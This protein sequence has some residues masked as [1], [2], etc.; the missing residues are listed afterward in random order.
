MTTRTF[1]RARAATAAANKDLAHIMA[2]IESVTHADDNEGR[3]TALVTLKTGAG[4]EIYD[5]V[6][7]KGFAAQAS[8]NEVT[9]D[10]LRAAELKALPLTELDQYG[11]GWDEETAVCPHCGINHIANGW[12]EY[13]SLKADNLHQGM[14]NEYICLACDGQFGP[15]IKKAAAKQKTGKTFVI[16]ER[17]T[18]DSPVKKVWAIANSMPNE[19]RKMVIAACVEAGVAYSTARTQYQH[20]FKANK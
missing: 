10:M 12:Q 17:S 7:A 16:T 14:T 8:E 3:F 18:V 11:H 13:F 6:V 1:S 4:K 15:A 5:A 2:F 19:R 9:D 20:W